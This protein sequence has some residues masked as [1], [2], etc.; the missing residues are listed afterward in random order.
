MLYLPVGMHSMLIMF[1][2]VDLAAA[3]SECR[4]VDGHNQYGVEKIANQG[5]SK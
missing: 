2:V 1:F 4:V 3:V 5:K